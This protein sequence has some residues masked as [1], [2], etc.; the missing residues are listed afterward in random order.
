MGLKALT[1]HMDEK[2]VDD[3]RN[4][5]KLN[6]MKLSA[7]VEMLLRKE[8]ETAHC[9]PTLVK[10]FEDIIDK[11]TLKTAGSSK[12]QSKIISKE[13]KKENNEE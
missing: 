10:L 9:N 2:I 4:Y 3:F 7:K 5:C 12:N 6:A 11:Q 13:E 8:M 1:L